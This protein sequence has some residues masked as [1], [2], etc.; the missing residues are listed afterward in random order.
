M[1]YLYVQLW[2][3]GLNRLNELLN[4]DGRHELN[5]FS[6][7]EVT[8]F[9]KNTNENIY[10]YFIIK[11]RLF[12]SPIHDFKCKAKEF[13]FDLTKKRIFEFT[14]NYSGKISLLNA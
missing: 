5:T 3:T 12:E 6:Q 1:P 11:E 13:I 4:K 14:I 9:L 7:L 8:F 2:K 10:P